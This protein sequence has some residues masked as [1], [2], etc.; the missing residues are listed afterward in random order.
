MQTGAFAL[1]DALGFKGIWQR[2][3]PSE[4]L[5]SLRQMSEG[6]NNVTKRFQSRVSFRTAFLSDT[7][8]LGVTLDPIGR[9]RTSPHPDRHDWRDLRECRERPRPA[10]VQGLCNL[11]RVR[12]GRPISDRSSR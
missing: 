8:A 7:I 11:W 5:A 3:E 10:L 2:H 1:M 12:D 4:V 9:G 6:V